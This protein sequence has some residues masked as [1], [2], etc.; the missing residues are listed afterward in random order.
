M[1]LVSGRIDDVTARDGLQLSRQEV[2]YRVDTF[3]VETKLWD[4]LGLYEE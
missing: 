2:S 1:K 4:Q 3:D